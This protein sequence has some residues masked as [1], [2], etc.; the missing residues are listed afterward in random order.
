VRTFRTLSV[1][2]LV[3]LVLAACGGDGG[4]GSTTSAAATPTDVPL[5]EWVDGMCT[6][7]GDFQSE[8][9]SAAADF[10][11]DTADLDSLK[12][13]WM[14][15]L[16]GMKDDTQNAI[17]ELKALGTPDTEGTAAADLVAAFQG[18]ADSIDQLRASAEDLDTGNPQ[19]FITAFQAGLEDFQTSAGQA[20]EATQNLGA[21]LEQAIA[22]SS[23]CQG[24]SV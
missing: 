21:D 3:A 19:S 10:T 13:S 17:D 1:V 4:E 14:D 11:P 23:A 2:A 22:D 8:V 6:T 16:D 5:A 20:S 24:I 7:L 18:I 9:Q 15:F 12:Q